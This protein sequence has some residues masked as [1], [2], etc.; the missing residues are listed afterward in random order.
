MFK[1]TFQDKADFKPHNVEKEEKNAKIGNY[2][3]DKSNR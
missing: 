3:S 1:W 2:S